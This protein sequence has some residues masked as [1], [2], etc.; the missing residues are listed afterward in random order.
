MIYKILL[1][2]CHNLLVFESEV[3]ESSI[4]LGNVKV[5]FQVHV[6]LPYTGRVCVDRVHRVVL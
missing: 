5:R 1:K 6:E 4:L 2:G 3:K